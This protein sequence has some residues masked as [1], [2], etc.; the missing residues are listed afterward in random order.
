MSF[1]RC[2][3]RYAVEER[4]RG[5]EAQVPLN[6]KRLQAIRTEVLPDLLGQAWLISVYI[7]T[8]TDSVPGLEMFT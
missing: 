1:I 2:F 6:G 5:N 8:F 3:E 7:N 4:K